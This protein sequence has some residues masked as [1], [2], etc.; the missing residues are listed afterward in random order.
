MCINCNK[1]YC[2]C[3][4]YSTNIE[5][6]SD[7]SGRDG[8]DAYQLAK[9]L[10]KPNT[11]TLEDWLDHLPAGKDGNPGPKGDPAILIVDTVEELKSIPQSEIDRLISGS[12]KCIQL[13]GYYFKDDTPSSIE[14]Y[15]YD[16]PIE[17]DGGSIFSIGNIKVKHDFNQTI[18]LRYYGLIKSDSN[19]V[20]VFTR[21]INNNNFKGITIPYGY[22]VN[23]NNQTIPLPKMFKIQVEGN[24]SNGII[25]GDE[26]FIDGVAEQPI[27]DSIRFRGTFRNNGK[28]YTYRNVDEL[29][30]YAHWPGKI[31]Q[32]DCFYFD[33]DKGGGR[34]EINHR[35]YWDSK[36]QYFKTYWYDTNIAGGAGLFLPV[37]SDRVLYGKLIPQG[38][39]INLSL[40]GVKYD[41]MFLNPSDQR[42]Y[43]DSNFTILAT[44][45]HAKLDAAIKQI[46]FWSSRVLPKTLV[47]SSTLVINNKLNL[48]HGDYSFKLIGD[49]YAEDSVITSNTNLDALIENYYSNSRPNDLTGSFYVINDI[50]FKGHGR[51]NNGIV[52]KNGYEADGIDRVQFHDFVRD[53]IVF[54]GI[55]STFK[56]GTISCFRNGRFGMSITST[57]PYRTTNNTDNVD[58]LLSFYRVSGDLN[59]QALIGIDCTSVGSSINL[60]SIKSERNNDSTIKI[61]RSSPRQYIS[62]DNAFT[63]GTGN[64][65]TIENYSD[66]LPTI[67]FKGIFHNDTSSSKYDIVDKKNNKNIRFP[68]NPTASFQH[69]IYTNAVRSYHNGYTVYRDGTKSNLDIYRNVGTTAQRP[70]LSID[71]IGFE[72]TDTQL[73]RK[74]WWN[75]TSWINYT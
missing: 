35:D 29:L 66:E 40:F 42:Y 64:F 48:T 7:V 9:E 6:N 2:T 73:M 65:L 11:E 20:N 59:G 13:N 71:D 55:S 8:K 33:N 45:N 24:L 25:T 74:L 72:Y 60:Q 38:N 19:Q 4:N 51:V 32:T 36:F 3:N 1:R 53:G 56:V 5:I 28:V 47:L 21:A 17:E 58:G 49:S 44:D 63:N 34:Y 26:T 75:G 22:K 57:H 37:S 27:T 69:L 68:K 46:R 14:Y 31:V 30:K 67:E 52:V 70:T 18:D 54:Y 41:A 16:G 62:I 15:F 23:L 50:T 39:T 12:Y 61:L 43:S 10:G